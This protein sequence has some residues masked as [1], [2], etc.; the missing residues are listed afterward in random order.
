MKKQLLLFV[1]AACGLCASEQPAAKE[2]DI[3]PSYI[4]DLGFNREIM[5]QT[6]PGCIPA[7][8]LDEWPVVSV[9]NGIRFPPK[10][11]HTGFVG[12]ICGVVFFRSAGTVSLIAVSHGNSQL[13]IEAAD[14]Y[15]RGLSFAPPKKGGRSVA[16]VLSFE[17]FVT[18]L[19]TYG[20]IFERAG[21][22][23]NQPSGRSQADGSA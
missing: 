11:A 17:C 9:K 2:P 3:R 1:C 7:K 13:L 19:G 22:K 12:Y 14:E 23:P 10:L 16:V 21:R 4:S 15:V 8:E 5:F 20:P 18:E 6:P